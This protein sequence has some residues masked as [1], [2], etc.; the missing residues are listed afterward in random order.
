MFVKIPPTQFGKPVNIIRGIL[1]PIGIAINST[2]EVLVAKQHGDV[3]VLDKN[4]K[5]LY[6][7]AISQ[8][9][10]EELRGITVNDDDNIYLTNQGTRK[11]FKFDKNHEMVTV[12]EC[13]QHLV[14]SEQF[15]PWGIDILGE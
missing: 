5:K 3:I 14:D 9:H 2:G 6:V 4:G 1:G 8:Y 10:F 15:N 7:I 13:G 11:L 12:I